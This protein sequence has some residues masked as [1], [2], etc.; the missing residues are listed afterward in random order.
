MAATCDER[1]APPQP[2]QLPFAAVCDMFE[3]LAGKKT[4]TIRQLVRRFVQ[5]AV[6][7][8]STGA[9]QLIRLDANLLLL[10]VQ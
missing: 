1:H 4:A 7:D 10:L 3:S 2:G 5:A 6:P 9:Y 8:G